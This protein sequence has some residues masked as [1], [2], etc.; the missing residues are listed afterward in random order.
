MIPMLIS[1]CMT[2]TNPDGC[3]QVEPCCL[4][5]RF[6]E[7]VGPPHGQLRV[8]KLLREA[9]HLLHLHFL[10]GLR[11]DVSI[12]KVAT[13]IIVTGLPFSRRSDSR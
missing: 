13:A 5:T 1:L 3:L 10:A 2:P 11:G 12:P 6:G 9:L 7:K 8:Y 4:S